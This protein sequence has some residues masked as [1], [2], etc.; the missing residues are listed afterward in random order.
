MMSTTSPSILIVEDEA[1]IATEIATALS[2]LGYRI[3]GK[4]RN[5]D[6]ALD[7]LASTRPDLAL[8]D[9]DIKGSLNGIDLARIIREKYDYPFVFLTAFSDRETVRRLADTMPYGY[10][11]KPFT[12]GELLT[13][14]ELAL[15]KFSAERDGGFP[16]LEMLNRRLTRGLTEREY[17]VLRLLNEGHA[18]RVIGEQLFISVNTVKYH[19][20]TLFAKLSVNSRLEAIRA[21]KSLS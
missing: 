15:H 19:Q 16:A 11:V 17:D 8:L 4:V 21:I 2:K 6:K 5:G 3:A 9:I 13:T 12:R 10:I 1:L 20:K 14:I 18:Y 7:L